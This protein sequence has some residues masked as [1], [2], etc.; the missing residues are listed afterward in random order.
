VKEEKHMLRSRQLRRLAGSFALLTLL[1]FLFV[2]A[3]FYQNIRDNANREIRQALRDQAASIGARLDSEV[4]DLDRIALGML[5]SKDFV[6]ALIELQVSRS[7]SPQD[8]AKL[9]YEFQKQVDRLI[10]TLNT[11]ILTSPMIDVFDETQ[12]DFFGW[13]IRGLDQPAIRRALGSIPWVE[14]AAALK[15][16]KLLVPVRQNEWTTRTDPVFSIVRAVMTTKD[17]LLGILEV[18]QGADVI[19]DA[20]A[21]GFPTQTVVV[22]NDRGER[23]YPLEP[24][25]F[26]DGLLKA[27]GAAQEGSVRLDGLTGARLYASKRSEYTG[28]TTIALRPEDDVLHTAMLAYRLVAFSLIAV[29]LISLTAVFLISRRLTAP[30]RA[31]RASVEQADAAEPRLAPTEGDGIDEVSQLKQSFERLLKRIDLSTR[32]RVQAQQEE[33][34]AHLL[35]LQS[36]MSPHFLY[37]TLNTIGLIAEENGQ[38]VVAD[39]SRQLVGMLRYVGDFSRSKVPLSEEIAH[40]EKYLSLLKSRYEDGLSYAIQVTGDA[41]AVVVP[42]LIL[43]PLCENSY[44]HGLNQVPPPWRID[45]AVEARLDGGFEIRVTDNGRGFS[46]EALRD[47]RERIAGFR[48]AE[49]PATGVKQMGL[50]NIGLISTHSRLFIE[51]GGRVRL[52]IQNLEGGGCAVT[53]RV[54]GGGNA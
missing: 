15:G 9:K 35:A 19:E 52:D 42:K 36:Q 26:L 40:C 53:I 48:V 49:N 4:Y 51:Y 28:W 11:P 45:V 39:I 47:V 10:F 8:L 13:S 6:D 31:L 18:Q 3:I 32:Q 50:D 46:E 41:D 14:D 33:A 27:A 2:F 5:G 1:T 20:C 12:G 30:I 37:N 38:Q 7:G 22:V 23:I 43:Q 17:K 24:V 34:R 54:E 21:S 44:L 16:A 25:G 29:L